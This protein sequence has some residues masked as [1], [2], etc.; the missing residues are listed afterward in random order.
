MSKNTIMWTFITAVLSAFVYIDVFYLWG[1]F[2][3]TIPLAVLSAIISMIISFK[4]KQS[5][6]IFLN[7]LLAIIAAISFIIIPW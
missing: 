3:V 5:V 7:L 6:F 4:E 2:F 1:I